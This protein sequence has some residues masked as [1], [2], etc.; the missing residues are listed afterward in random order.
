MDFVTKGM[1]LY[2]SLEK[3]QNPDVVYIIMKNSVNSGHIRIVFFSP[4]KVKY[5]VLRG[6]GHQ[7]LNS[8]TMI[9]GPQI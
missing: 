4:E 5:I 1:Y 3:R 7:C 9:S 8:G 2:S 6:D